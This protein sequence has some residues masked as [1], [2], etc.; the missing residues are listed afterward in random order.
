MD[1]GNISTLDL[2]DGNTKKTIISCSNKS[3]VLME[4][5]KFNYDEF[6]KFAS[7]TDISSIIT[8]QGIINK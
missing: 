7:I 2:E 6:F 4:N 5:E 1:T 8:E 3:Y